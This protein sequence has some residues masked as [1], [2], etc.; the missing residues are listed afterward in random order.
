MLWA[1]MCLIGS[2]VFVRH[3][4]G[5]CIVAFLVWCLIPSIA[6][7]RINGYDLVIAD[8]HP[9]S[10]LILV[11]LVVQVCAGS[12]ELKHAVAYRPGTLMLALVIVG[13][14]SVMGAVG[15]GLTAVGPTVNE[16]VAPLTLFFLL[17]GCLL[18]QPHRVEKVRRL[19]LV[20]AA[21]EASFAVAQTVSVSPLVWSVYYGRQFW[22]TENF[23]R[24][25][26]TFDHPL[27]LSVFLSCAI[28]L[29]VDIRRW[30]LSLLLLCVYIGGLL[31]TQSRTGFAA[32]AVGALYVLVRGRFSGAGKFMFMAVGSVI[33]VVVYRL[34]VGT[35]L[36]DRV[37]DD[38]GSSA[39]RVQALS[40]FVDH[41][42]DFLWSGQG[43]GSN[44]TLARQVG[45]PTSFE[46]AGVMYSIDLGIVVAVLYFALM[47]SVLRAAHRT[48]SATGMV[49][50]A[51]A[52]ILMIQTF[53]ALSGATTMPPIL[54]S[55]LALA[56]FSPTTVKSAQRATPVS[57]LQPGLRPVRP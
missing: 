53:S 43:L 27:I 1:G 22:F 17:G 28:F 52:A 33:A 3:L 9:A 15:R 26:G 51:I 10:V 19:I 13:A 16:L 48:G 49:P 57:T 50:A 46:S 6:S 11:T 40:Y 34:G 30:W 37:A 2:I 41:W 54:W 4:F 25:M 47:V 42:T 45:L 18:L 21:G 38:N 7:P 20:L 29:L 24:W 36:T 55:L 44:F 35:S 56:G 39:A 31:C 5:W 8:I 23:H 14:A 32:A 12:A